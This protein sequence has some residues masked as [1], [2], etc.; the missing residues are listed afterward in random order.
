[1]ENRMIIQ[2]VLSSMLRFNSNNDNIIINLVVESVQHSQN[3]MTVST[4]RSGIVVHYFE[5]GIGEFGGLMFN[6]FC[7]AEINQWKVIIK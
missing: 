6:V 3:N 5:D 2:W 7:P 4:W 1:M